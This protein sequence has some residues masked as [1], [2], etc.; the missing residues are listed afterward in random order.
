M[1]DPKCFVIGQIKKE[2]W[3]SNRSRVDLNAFETEGASA[4]SFLDTG[5]PG[6]LVGVL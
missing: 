6:P 5:L 2:T 3:S 4:F 1:W